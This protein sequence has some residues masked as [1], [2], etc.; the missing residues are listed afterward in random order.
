LASD[1]IYALQPREFTLLARAD[2]GLIL[3]EQ[4]KDREAMSQLSQALTL[5]PNFTPAH[6]QLGLLLMKMGKT[7][8]ARKQF[9]WLVTVNPGDGEAR[10]YLNQLTAPK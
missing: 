5:D 10:E 8:E 7:E 4:G 6:K 2:L 1:R 3:S 9:S